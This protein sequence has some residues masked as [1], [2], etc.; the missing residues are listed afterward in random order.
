[1]LQFPLYCFCYQEESF[2]ELNKVKNLKA[3]LVN[4]EA[5][6]NEIHLEMRFEMNAAKLSRMLPPLLQVKCEIEK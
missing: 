6:E 2:Q 3:F 4:Q 5:I 1:M